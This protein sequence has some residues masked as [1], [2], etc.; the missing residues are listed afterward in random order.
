MINLL[1]LSQIYGSN[2]FDICIG[3]GLPVLIYTVFNGSIDMNLPINRI[4]F[5]GNYILGGNL[6]IWSL[7]VLFV[8]SVLVS[9]IFIK[10][11]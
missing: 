5:I 9:L 4:G 1:I 3:I 6:F 8:F 11:N 2:I 10:S 7:V